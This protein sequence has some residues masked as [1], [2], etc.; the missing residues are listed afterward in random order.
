MVFMLESVIEEHTFLTKDVL[1]MRLGDIRIV[2]T[3]FSKLDL[4]LLVSCVLSVKLSPS[5]DTPNT[6]VF[7]INH[8]FADKCSE[9]CESSQLCGP[10]NCELLKW[11]AGYTIRSPQKALRPHLRQWVPIQTRSNWSMADSTRAGSLVRIPASKLRRRLL[12]MPM[13]APVRLAE[14]M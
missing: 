12:F 1:P 2:F 13:P 3:P 11:A 9:N 6:N 14:P 5:T 4:I 8:C 7:S 10:Q